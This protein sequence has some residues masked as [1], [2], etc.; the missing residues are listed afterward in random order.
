MRAFGVLVLANVLVLTGALVSPLLA[1]VLLAGLEA[2]GLL[3]YASLLRATQR[4][5]FACK[6]ELSTIRPADRQAAQQ[7]QAAEAEIARQTAIA[8][9]DGAYFPE[10]AG[11][12]AAAIF[13]QQWSDMDYWARERRG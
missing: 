13:E 5:L 1:V 2:G 9:R 10:A 3:L 6:L 7:R 11:T 4:E 12:D 8:R